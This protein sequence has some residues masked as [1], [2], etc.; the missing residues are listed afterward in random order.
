MLSNTDII[1]N[2]MMNEK[3]LNLLKQKGI[4]SNNNNNNNEN[5]NN[6]DVNQSKNKNDKNLSSQ[7]ENKTI[8]ENE[9]ENTQVTD[10]SQ[11]GSPQVTFAIWN[12]FRFSLQV[13]GIIFLYQIKTTKWWFWA[14][15]IYCIFS[16]VPVFMQSIANLFLTVYKLRVLFQRGSLKKGSFRHLLLKEIFRCI[17]VG[18]G[19]SLIIILMP[20]AVWSHYWPLSIAS[21]F[22]LFSYVVLNSVYSV[23]VK[24]IHKLILFIKKMIKKYQKM[25][26]PQNNKKEKPSPVFVNELNKKIN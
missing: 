21:L 1:L 14:A 19:S 26:L 24:A 25:K 20:I 3:Q 11:K 18:F 6:M 13:L 5:N 12:T 22:A 23:L 10:P 16:A 8:K 7:N 17:L 15:I 2:N 9:K 4:L